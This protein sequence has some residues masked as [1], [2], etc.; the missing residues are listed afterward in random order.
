MIDER[1]QRILRAVIE[2][3]I[4]TGEPV[5]SR[6]IARKHGFNVSPAT[7]RNEMADLEELGF[8][9]QPHT[10]AGRV[11]SDLGYRYYVDH[12]V[13]AVPAD[14]RLW[15]F[16]RDR[17]ALRAR[18]IGAAVRA[19]ARMLSEASNFLALVSGPHLESAR[20]DALRIVPVGGQRAL[21]VVVTDTGIVENRLLEL[22]QPLNPAEVERINRLFEERV[23]GQTMG[24]AALAVMKDLAMELRQYGDLVEQTL[25]VL[26]RPAADGEERLV[27]GGATN[28]LRQ[29][30]FRDIDK[31]QMLLG[32]LEQEETVLELLGE[33]QPRTRARVVIG[34]EIR[35]A[36]MQDCSLVTA[37]YRIGGDSW[38]QV[39]VLGP[40]R[41]DYAKI[42]SLVE[43]VA[44][45]LSESLPRR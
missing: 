10:S 15:Q 37:S 31:A 35:V 14:H 13:R 9:E 18:E 42:I 38:G 19:A 6:T 7:I 43:A 33:P 16:M 22:G 36:E 44:R 29:P 12:F 8:L 30:E 27:V 40:R 17:L 11:P 4:S 41:M 3:Y 34:H 2:D 32:S 45:A 23:C 28:I 26:D 20:I 5:G 24:R 39:G 25:E 1:K 21:F